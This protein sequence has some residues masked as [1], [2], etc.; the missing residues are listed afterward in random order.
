[1]DDTIIWEIDPKWLERGVK[2][3]IPIWIMQSSLNKDGE[4]YNLPGVCGPIFSRIGSGDKMLG[5]PQLISAMNGILYTSL[6]LLSLGS[7]SNILVSARNVMIWQ[8]L[9]PPIN[10][11]MLESN[12]CWSICCIFSV[13][14]QCV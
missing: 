2:E 8:V 6:K 9:V 7:T 10:C 11:T 4:R 5:P 1:M 12:T 14:K 13:Y 3:T